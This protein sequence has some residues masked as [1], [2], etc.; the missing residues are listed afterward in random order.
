MADNLMT[1]HVQMALAAMCF[2]EA[3]RQRGGHVTCAF[4]NRGRGINS[5]H[6]LALL[7]ELLK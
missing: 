5:S 2:Y 7:H 4:C 1:F 3:R 6:A